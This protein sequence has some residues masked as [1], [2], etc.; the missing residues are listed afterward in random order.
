MGLR[1]AE[2]FDFNQTQTELLRKWDSNSVTQIGW[3]WSTGRWGGSSLLFG[4]NNGAFVTLYKTLDN[5]GTWVL[6]V[7]V[8]MTQLGYGIPLFG[9]R[10]GTTVQCHLTINTTGWTF[11]RGA[12]SATL[13]SG[14]WNLTNNTW[15]YFEA[16]I[17][18]HATAG[19]VTLRRD[20]VT[21]NTTTGINT[22][23]SG[24]AQANG[25]YLG[26]NVGGSGGCR[27][28]CDDFYACDGTG[29]ANNDFLGAAPDGARVVVSIPMAPGTNNA[30]T[31]GPG[32]QAASYRAKV[33]SLNPLHY[34]DFQEASGTSLADYGTGTLQ[35]GT[36]TGLTVA[37]AGY[38]NWGTAVQGPADG[39]GYVTVPYQ[40]DMNI[41][42]SFTFAAWLYLDSWVAANQVLIR[43]M[44]ASQPAFEFGLQ[45]SNVGNNQQNA[46]YFNS[47][48]SVLGYS[49]AQFPTGRWVHVVAIRDLS[50]NLFNVYVDGQLWHTTSWTVAG[51][52]GGTAALYLMN[53]ANG[54]TN[55]WRGRMAHPAIWN[56]A[57]TA[58][59]AVSLRQWANF[60]AHDEGGGLVGSGM[61]NMSNVTQQGPNGDSTY[62][63]SSNVGDTD[64]YGM[65]DLPAGVSAVRGFL[66]TTVARKDSPGTR[67]IAP[68]VRSGATDYPQTAVALTDSYGTYLQPVDVDPAT[69]AAWT[70][71][72]FNAVEIGVRVTA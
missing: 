52:T 11:Y 30:W 31:A 53:S 27:F 71:A 58:A 50:S 67:S 65:A 43:H 45:A 54:A 10:D 66:I 4:E 36:A 13:A 57:L 44:G 70:N 28:Y 22:S 32:S 12:G 64:T 9:L 16:K 68:V 48:G 17:V 42:G 25:I 55:G 1:H 39:S 24:N 5:Q 60:A 46:F 38:E 72:N 20:G 21:F 49:F 3:T 37:R 18:V 41:S 40:A 62:V 33:L 7:A 34:W 29:T 35:A 69:S 2:T 47:N 6:G 15:Y 56:V 59:Q 14:N 51:G 63:A 26:T 61:L 23:A 8:N 19:S